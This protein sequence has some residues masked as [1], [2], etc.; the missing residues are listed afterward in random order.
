[1]QVGWP[2]MQRGEEKERRVH[3]AA[4]RLAQ[5]R[6]ARANSVALDFCPPTFSATTSS[7][8]RERYGQRSSPLLLSLVRAVSE[9][10]AG[11]ALLLS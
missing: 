1:M 4:Q 5:K 8:R 9:K 2:W 11:G 6:V 10:G 3:S 7:G